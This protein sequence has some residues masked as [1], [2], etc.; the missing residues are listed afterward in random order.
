MFF[1]SITCVDDSCR[2]MYYGQAVLHVVPPVT[3]I[4][5]IPAHIVVMVR[6]QAALLNPH[7][8]DINLMGFVSASATVDRPMSE[9]YVVIGCGQCSRGS[10]FG[11]PSANIQHAF[12]V[13][14]S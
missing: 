7:R 12:L 13:E 8:G 4:E 10:C 9:T 14:V 1:Q 6:M 11:L 5:F 2:G 3:Y